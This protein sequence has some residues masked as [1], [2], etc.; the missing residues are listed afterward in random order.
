MSNVHDTC[1]SLPPV[2]QI[3]RSWSRILK[4]TPNGMGD[5]VSAVAEHAAVN[6]WRCTA[7]LSSVEIKIAQALS[8]SAVLASELDKHRSDTGDARSRAVL[9]VD[10][11]ALLFSQVEPSALAQVA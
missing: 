1:G 4:T 3:L 11:L 9:A 2:F 10:T 5:T 7:K 8:A 6:L